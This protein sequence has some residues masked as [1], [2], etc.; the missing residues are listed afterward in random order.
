VSD[1]DWW[2]PCWGA[3][4]C[5]LDF[6][7]PEQRAATLEQ[8]GLMAEVFENRGDMRSANFCKALTGEP[9]EVP[10]PKSKPK[11]IVDNDR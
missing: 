9:Y 10:A 6:M 2:D 8:L 1:L 7:P 3:L 4:S 5:I 11:L